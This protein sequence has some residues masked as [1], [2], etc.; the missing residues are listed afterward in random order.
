MSSLSESQLTELQ[1]HLQA[2][3]VGCSERG[4]YQATKWCETLTANHYD[5]HTCCL[6]ALQGGRAT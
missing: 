2:A 4:L 5:M 6:T 3:V 1:N